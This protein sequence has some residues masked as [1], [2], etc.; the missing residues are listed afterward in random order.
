MNTK[1]ILGVSL[2][3]IFAVSMI[4]TQSAFA[5]GPPPPSDGYK[6][7]ENLVVTK[8]SPGNTVN[9]TFDTAGM[10]PK[11]GTAPEGAFGYGLVTT[12]NNDG[13]PEDVLALTTHKCVSDSFKQGDSAD[14]DEPTAGLLEALGFP[15]GSNELHD[16]ET[17]HAHVLDLKG[18]VDTSSCSTVA[19]GLG[20][21][22]DLDRTVATGNNISPDWTISFNSDMDEITVSDVPRKDIKSSNF[23][24]PYLAAYFGIVGF[25][26]DDGETI[27]NLC[28]TDGTVQPAP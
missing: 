1:T 25:V 20:L 27:S 21:E 22:V 16:D 4:A 5:G 26:A 17:F 15:A 12:L 28:L 23:K 2:A 3:A 6:T 24:S 13:L 10:I 18:V 14:C 9:V 8:N 11:D 7:V 19:G